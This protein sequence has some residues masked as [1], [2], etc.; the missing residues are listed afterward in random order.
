M[1]CDGVDDPQTYAETMNR[2]ILATTYPQFLLN[3]VVQIVGL[4]IVFV[5]FRDRNKPFFVKLIWGLL[6]IDLVLNLA[7]GYI[8]LFTYDT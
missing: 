2:V 4:Y 1:L 3:L 6:T 5:H 7:F 8:H